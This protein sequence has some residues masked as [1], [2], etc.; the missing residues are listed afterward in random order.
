MLSC[1]VVLWVFIPSHGNATGKNCH[2]KRLGWRMDIYLQTPLLLPAVRLYVPFVLSEL[3]S[4]KH[5]CRG[6]D[7]GVDIFTLFHSTEGWQYKLLFCPMAC[8]LFV[9]VHLKEKRSW[10]PRWLSC[11]ELVSNLSRLYCVHVVIW[12]HFKTGI[13]LKWIIITAVI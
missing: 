7:Q 5:K 1:F 9:P 3:W 10:T 4:I 12:I 2:D 13:V 11:T 6:G 8:G